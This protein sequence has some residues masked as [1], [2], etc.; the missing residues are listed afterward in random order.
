M[1][2]ALAKP[3]VSRFVFTAPDGIRKKPHPIL[4]FEV[5]RYGEVSL[6]PGERGMLFF[7]KWGQVLI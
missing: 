2:R 7:Q 5:G 6:V 3:I 1:G 4:H